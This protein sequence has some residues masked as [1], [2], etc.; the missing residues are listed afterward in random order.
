MQPVS[1]E[2]RGFLP[3]KKIIYRN[4]GYSL[5]LLFF[6]HH[7]YQYLSYNYI[8]LVQHMLVSCIPGAMS[9]LFAP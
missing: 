3:S 2:F 7:Y 1:L 5:I 8:T 6:V 9:L 4:V